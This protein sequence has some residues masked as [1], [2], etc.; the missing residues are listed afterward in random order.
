MTEEV[1]AYNERVRVLSRRHWLGEGMADSD[2]AT[3]DE[4]RKQYR[5]TAEEYYR[6]GQRL[7]EHLT[8]EDTKGGM[9]QHAFFQINRNVQLFMAYSILWEAFAHIYIAAACSDFARSGADRGPVE[10]ERQKIDR[11]LRPPYLLP[12]D[13]KHITLLK[14]GETLA[15]A[16]TRMS[17]HSSRELE[18]IYDVDDSHTIT[19]MEAFMLGHVR[20]ETATDADGNTT[21][22]SE[23]DNWFVRALD[24]SGVPLD[25]ERPFDAEKYRSVVKWHC[26]QI[27]RNL[28]FVGKSAG[29][30]DDA[31]L[32]IRAF[33]LLEPIVGIL[34]QE[35]RRELVFAL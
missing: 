16:I 2:R 28:N 22:L 9:V 33:C 7:Y 17:S 18:A 24:D 21:P 19:D 27:R 26:Y 11:V 15:G 30:I 3:V 6:A 29:S 14:N 4:I 25:P 1:R 34:L 12:E 13:L 20:V 35:S 8:S 5:A 31:I 32:L 10:D 23:T